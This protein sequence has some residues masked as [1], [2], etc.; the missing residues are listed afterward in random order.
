MYL[1][2]LTDGDGAHHWQPGEDDGAD[3]QYAPTD[4]S[5][6]S[7]EPKG[8]EHVAANHEGAEYRVYWRRRTGGG[9]ASG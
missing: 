4:E 1:I 2:M 9:A 5:H 3:H 8:G 7:S 6:G